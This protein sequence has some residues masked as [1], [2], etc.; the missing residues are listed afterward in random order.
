MEGPFTAVLFV[1]S[2]NPVKLQPVVKKSRESLSFEV[3]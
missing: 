1:S 3:F 2:E